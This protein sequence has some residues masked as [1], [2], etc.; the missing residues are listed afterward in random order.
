MSTFL[1]HFKR[2]LSLMYMGVLS[3]YKSVHHIYAVP[4]RPEEGSDILGLKLRMVVSH[5][6]GSRNP[7][8]DSGRVASAWSYLL[9]L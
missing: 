1:H 7:T 6:L 4:V 2:L 5:H 9:F 3:A 8:W